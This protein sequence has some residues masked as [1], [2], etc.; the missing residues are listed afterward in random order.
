MSEALGI[1]LPTGRQRKQAIVISTCFIAG[2]SF[3]ISILYKVFEYEKRIVSNEHMS[4]KYSQVPLSLAPSPS[5][6]V[7]QVAVVLVL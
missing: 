5:S 1:E 3:L 2:G 7:A 4:G 6:T